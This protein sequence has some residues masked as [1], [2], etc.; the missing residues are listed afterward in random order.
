MG[1]LAGGFFTAVGAGGDVINLQNASCSQEG[2]GGADANIQIYNTGAQEGEVW[3][4]DGGWTY[5]HD[6][7]TPGVNANLYQMKWDLF[8]G[9]PPSGNNT[10][11]EGVWYPLSSGDFEVEWSVPSGDNDEAGSVTVSLRLGSGPSVLATAI[12]DGE[13]ISV[14]KGQ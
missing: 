8:S 3:V 7:I 10:E 12:W 13:A 6:A 5:D 1:L 9:D 2:T 14:K 4:E 11:V